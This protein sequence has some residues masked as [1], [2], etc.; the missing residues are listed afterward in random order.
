[1]ATDTISRPT[2]AEVITMIKA[3][4]GELTE[5]IDAQTNALLAAAEG[6]DVTAEQEAL[7]TWYRTELVPHALAEEDTLYRAG[8]TLTAS[9]LLVN[10][11]I[12]EH[13]AIVAAIDELSTA[14]TP[15]A[16]ALAA[17]S[18]R[19]L[20]A[21]HMVKENDLLLPA[22]DAAGLDLAALL[23]GMHDIL[24]ESQP[25]GQ[26]ADRG[27]SSAG[28]AHQQAVSD[29]ELDVRSEEPRRRHELILG[30]FVELPVGRGYVLVNDHDPKPLRYQFEVEYADQFSWEYLEEGPEVWRVR[31][32][33]VAAA[34]V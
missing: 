33:R 15:L 21:V 14:R 3:H 6:G 22:L 17:S 20:F 13:K 29:P 30:T 32:G 34:T 5:H 4:H 19:S 28:H 18:V 7:S 26:N 24:G 25:V 9:A 12:D 27:G 1:M 23:D 31:I 11:M 16:A 8:S 2:N 10:A